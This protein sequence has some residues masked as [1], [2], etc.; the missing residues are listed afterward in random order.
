MLTIDP[1]LHQSRT[2]VR[3][4]WIDRNNHV[5]ASYYLAIVKEP[6]IELHERWDY[7]QDFVDRT[8]ES[9]FVINAEVVYLREMLLGDE[10]TVVSRLVDLDDKRIRILFEI[11]NTTRRY[12][13]ALVQYHVIHVRLGPPPKAVSIP[14]DLR[15]RLQTQ[16]D[17]SRSI[18]LPVEVNRF[19]SFQRAQAVPESSM[20]G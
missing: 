8:G 12:L 6:A 1:R 16:L 20:V 10:V 4:E 17:L 18:P 11:V 19:K 3:P 14:P 9:N 15:Q 2:K 13:A 7:G 5:N